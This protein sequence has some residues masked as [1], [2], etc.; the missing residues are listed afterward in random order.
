VHL[1]KINITGESLILDLELLEI[2]GE[3]LKNEFK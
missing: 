3:E 2:I 1:T